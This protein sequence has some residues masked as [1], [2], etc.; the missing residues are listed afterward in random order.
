MKKMHRFI[1]WVLTFAVLMSI[2]TAGM[3]V[4]AESNEEGGETVA[5]WIKL[6]ISLVN[7][8]SLKE[9]LQNTIATLKP[10]IQALM[11]NLAGL[12]GR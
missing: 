2:F 10:A 7:W 1:A 12:F 11:Q 6:L 4:F 8:A 5:D 9:T 3:I